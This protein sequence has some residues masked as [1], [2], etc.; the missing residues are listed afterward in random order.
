[1]ITRSRFHNVRFCGSSTFLL[2]AWLTGLVA[3][4]GPSDN[5][6]ELEAASEEE[7]AAADNVE[8][9]H[10]GR[11]QNGRSAAPSEDPG[12]AE[13]YDPARLRYEVA[14]ARELELPDIARDPKLL[15]TV[16]APES[17]DGAPYPMVIF[18][19]GGGG[20]GDAFEN[21]SRRLAARGYVVVH[22]WHADSIE[23]ARR[24]GAS[25]FDESRGIEQ[26]MNRVD[27]IDRITDVQLIVRETEAIADLLGRPGLIDAA[28]LGMA[29][30]SAG[31]MTTQ[32]A[33]GVRL[34]PPRSRFTHGLV[35]PVPEISAFAI[36]SGQGTTRPALNEDSW[37]HCHRPMLVI[38]GSAD[39]VPFS[40]ETTESRRHP[41]EFA[42]AD[43]TKYLAFIDGATHDA[44]QGGGFDRLWGDTPPEN[45]DW[46]ERITTS[47]TVA[48]MDAYVANDE[49]ARAWL[50]QGQ[51][52]DIP[53]GELE[54]ETK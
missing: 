45:V 17:D 11:E 25:W 34:F 42:P 43:G 50:N 21:L 46:I 33:A 7:Q 27:L 29:G 38:T 51:V 30:H 41:F 44:Y 8:T 22:P 12:S 3:C 28:R 14:E 35:Q 10:A 37:Q 32:F 15:L 13:S 52:R 16:R 54:W 40:D 47:L 31:A 49:A 39:Q 2:I 4:S 1:M 24:R 36:I 20:S 6:A 19:H 9:A 26:V 48:M 5:A 53:G 18:S 23:L